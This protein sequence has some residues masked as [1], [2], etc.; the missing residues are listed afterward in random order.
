MMCVLQRSG[1]HGP[2]LS[3]VLLNPSRSLGLSVADESVMTLPK[4]AAISIR[5]LFW[6]RISGRALQHWRG[7]WGSRSAEW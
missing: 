5:R 7:R 2:R 4:I 3:L 6:I 1:S